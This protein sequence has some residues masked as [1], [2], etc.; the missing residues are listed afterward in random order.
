MLQFAI[1]APGMKILLFA[2]MVLVAWRW[3][4]W[5]LLGVA[6]GGDE[7]DDDG[8]FSLDLVVAVVE[9]VSDKIDPGM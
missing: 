8:V 2:T 4:W 9:D 6:A 3:R 1:A 7:D 5:W